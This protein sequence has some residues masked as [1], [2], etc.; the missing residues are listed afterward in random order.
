MAKLLAIASH[1]GDQ[2]SIWNVDDPT[3]PVLVGD[4]GALGVLNTCLSIVKVGDVLLANSD[5]NNRITQIDI[6][7]PAN[8]VAGTDEAVDI[9]YSSGRYPVAKDDTYGIFP[10]RD[11]NYFAVFEPDLDEAVW[12]EHGGYDGD[13]SGGMDGPQQAVMSSSGR[14]CYVNCFDDDLVEIMDLD[15]PSSPTRV[16][17]GFAVTGL[18]GPVGLAR[19][20]TTLFTS[21]GGT[22]YACTLD[23]EDDINLTPIDSIAVAGIRTMFPSTDG[24]YLICHDNSTPAIVVVDISDPS[25]MVERGSVSLPASVPEGGNVQVDSDGICY[26]PCG[27]DDSVQIIDFGS[28]PDN[29]VIL[30]EI[31]SGLNDARG[32]WFWS[33]AAPDAPT[34][35]AGFVGPT[36]VTLG[37]SAFSSPAPADTHLQTQWQVTAAADTSFSSPIEDVTSSEDLLVLEVSDLTVA[38]DYIARARH[39]GSSGVGSWSDTEEFTTVDVDLPDTPTLTVGDVGEETVEVSLSPFSHTEDPARTLLTTRFQIDVTAGDF[40]SPVYD[41]G[42]LPLADEAVLLILD[43]TANTGYKARG[44]HM[45]DVGAPS[46]WSTAQSFTTDATPI[47][48]PDKPSASASLIT[49]DSFRVTGSTYNHTMAVAHQA[50]Q[51]RINSSSVTTL[52]AV[53]Q[54][55]VENLSPGLQDIS[56]QIRYQDANDDWSEWSDAIEVDLLE[57]VPEPRITSPL[58]GKAFSSSPLVIVWEEETDYGGGDLEYEVGFSDDMGGS[59]STVATEIDDVTYNLDI[60]TLV[61]GD[62]AFRVRARDV[63]DDRVSDWVEVLFFVDN[64][65][66]ANIEV[67]I[68]SGFGDTEVKWDGYRTSWGGGGGGAQARTVNPADALIGQIGGPS[69]LTFPELGNPTQIEMVCTFTMF[70]DLSTPW[71]WLYNE[72]GEMRA[73]LAF[74]V[75]GDIPDGW[76]WN[77]SAG[78]H[79]PR[80]DSMISGLRTWMH[81]GSMRNVAADA[82]PLPEGVYPQHV[83]DQMGEDTLEGRG[84][85]EGA[86]VQFQ[87]LGFSDEA[88]TVQAN[89]YEQQIVNRTA[90]GETYAVSACNPLI[91]PV[92]T[93][94]FRA[95]Y[96]SEPTFNDDGTIQVLWRVRAQAFGPGIPMNGGWQFDEETDFE[97]RV[98]C[99]PCGLFSDQLWGI[100]SQEDAYIQYKSLVITILDAGAGGAPVL[101]AATSIPSS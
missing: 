78:G 59:W 38:T 20:G 2:I 41:S 63:S 16:G 31:Q 74:M 99:G 73:G 94:R 96:A 58:Q 14:Y 9:D 21:G 68:V 12:T 24:D 98:P 42:E 35:T 70:T 71:Y 86:N 5:L 1:D 53:E 84:T 89:L 57:P 45:D 32:I 48:R 11:D 18:T 36:F 92:Y 47:N 54:Y 37:T 72:S 7:D 85:T 33:D 80:D 22:I 15:D 29:P 43:L 64:T 75:A 17:T 23:A 10:F 82:C 6:S 34:L 55:D 46:A 13:S 62:Y 40:S 69:I 66:L 50:T 60:S 81:L 19:V 67:D 27:D 4:T 56:V 39:I 30:G 26:I 100:R 49:E 8:P 77:S 51:V 90:P 79:T 91:E 101:G 44:R 87:G 83:I 65:G 93:L 28:D 52:G 61:N 88:L 97:W 3:T 25:N 95:E 76:T